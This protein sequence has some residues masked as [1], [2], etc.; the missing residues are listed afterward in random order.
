ME[1]TDAFSLV[2]IEETL[3]AE[4]ED[5]DTTDMGVGLTYTGVEQTPGVKSKAG[6]DSELGWAEL[7][8]AGFTYKWEKSFGKPSRLMQVSLRVRRMFR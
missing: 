2:K 4:V 6:N 7:S 1:L 8:L 3:Q 5:P